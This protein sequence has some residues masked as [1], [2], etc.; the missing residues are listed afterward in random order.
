MSE[1]VQISII[2]GCFALLCILG[3]ALSYRYKLK[4]TLNA[5]EWERQRM[6]EQRRTD[7]KLAKIKNPQKTLKRMPK[8]FKDQIMDFLEMMGDERVAGLME[9]FSEKGEELPTENKI[10]NAIIP[11]A[12]GFLG[13][14]EEEEPEIEQSTKNY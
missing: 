2:S 13:R 1:L 11:L 6:R 4:L 8:G 10:I 3:L 5:N 9:M 14:M 7:V 12:E